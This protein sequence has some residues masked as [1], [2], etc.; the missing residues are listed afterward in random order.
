MRETAVVRR[1]DPLK[2]FH[3]AKDMTSMEI[4]R[5]DEFENRPGLQTRIPEAVLVSP[6]GHGG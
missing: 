3:I 4:T 2:I 5:S 1:R 6:H